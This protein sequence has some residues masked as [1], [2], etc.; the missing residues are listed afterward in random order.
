M[1]DNSEEIKLGENSTKQPKKYISIWRNKWIISQAGSIDDFIKIYE[2]LAEKMRKWKDK[3]IILDPDIIGA[4]GDDY[5]QFCTTDEAVA[6]QEGFEEEVFDEY[7]DEPSDSPELEFG[8]NEFITLKLIQGE[9]QIYVNGEKFDQCHYVL[10]VNPH[11]DEQQFEIE[12]ID[13]AQAVYKNDLETEVTPEDLGITKEQ[14]FWAHAS[15]LQAWAEN[16]YDSRLLHSNLAFPLLKKLTKVGDVNAK[17]VFKDEIAQR[18]ASGYIPVMAYL[19]KEKYLDN[20]TS[21]EFSTLLEEV[22]YSKLEISKLLINFSDF[23]FT[24]FT[25]QFLTKIKEE[26]HDF[27]NKNTIYVEL[28]D[29][30]LDKSE[31]SPVVI[32]PDSNYFIRGSDDGKLKEFNIISGELE[33]VFGDHDRSVFTVAISHDGKYV[34]SSSDETI[35]VWDYASGNLIYTLKGHQDFVICLRFDPEGGYLISGSIDTEIK[36]WNLENGKIKTTLGSHWGKVISLAFSKDGTYLVSGAGDKTVNIYD[37]QKGRLLTT[38]INH[39][40][41][42]LEV[43]ISADNKVVVSASYSD[44]T[45]WDLHEKKILSQIDA[46][47]GKFNL[48]SFVLTPDGKFIVA[49]L[50]GPL[51]EGGALSTWR[52]EDGEFVHAV[53]IRQHFG[54]YCQELNTLTISQDGVFIIGAARARMV[55]VWM[56]FRSYMEI[57]EGFLK[58]REKLYR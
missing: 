58:L 51:Q 7:N 37:A 9:T 57:E 3:G 27:F 35:K 25:F 21:E 22:N 1:E 16:N 30:K 19:F 31:F 23:M 49:G 38:F 33:R 34:A 26:F 2:S 4:I 45:I 5:A 10:L 48:I 24:D 28:A 56:D 32:T 54:G 44:L 12:S 42:I 50:Q 13:E 18:F 17:R 40:D 20:L 36:V 11:K 41:N 47:D 6:L 43:A 39:K 46:S 55:K 52:I 29:Y 8:V 53:P 15:N 14:E